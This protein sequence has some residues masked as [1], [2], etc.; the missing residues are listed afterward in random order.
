MKTQ[1]SV[2]DMQADHKHWLSEIERWENYVAVWEEQEKNLT[3][4]YTR[5]L[6]AVDQHGRHIKQHAHDVADLKATIIGCEQKMMGGH[7]DVADTL[8]N[9]HEKGTA[10]HDEQRAVHESLKQEHHTLMAA[11]AVFQQKPFQDE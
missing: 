6:H 11:M 2:T 3:E 9:Q 1:T 5:M 8:V 7:G 10:R 4:Q